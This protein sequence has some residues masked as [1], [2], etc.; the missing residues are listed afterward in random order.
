MVTI[1]TSNGLGRPLVATPKKTMTAKIRIVVAISP[2]P[3]S[4]TFKASPICDAKELKSACKRIAIKKKGELGAGIGKIS[5]P[6]PSLPFLDVLAN[7]NSPTT[8][9]ARPEPIQTKGTRPT[10]AIA[11]VDPVKLQPVVFR[12][13]TSSTIVGVIASHVI[14]MII[15]LIIPI[16]FEDTAPNVETS[17]PQYG[18]DTI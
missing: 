5:A 11:P 13:W 1:N 10:N 4:P 9:I 6:Y 8:S 18:L 17:K 14:A 2:P 15:M 12:F 16:T 3:K 7:A